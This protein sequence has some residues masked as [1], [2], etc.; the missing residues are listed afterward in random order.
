MEDERLSMNSAG[1]NVNTGSRPLSQTSSEVDSVGSFQTV[2]HRDKLKSQVK[3][4][5]EILH[6]YIYINNIGKIILNS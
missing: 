2:K 6:V 3:Y 4:S 1:I 5:V